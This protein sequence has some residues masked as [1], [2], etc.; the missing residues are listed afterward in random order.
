MHMLIDG[1]MALYYNYTLTM[2]IFQVLQ[3]ILDKLHLLFHDV[4]G[5][6]SCCKYQ[7]CRE[8]DEEFHSVACL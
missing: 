5:W 4:I 3:Y 6:Q 8:N 1:I 7:Q 2:G